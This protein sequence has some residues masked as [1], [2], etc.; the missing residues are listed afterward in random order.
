M[1]LSNS[2]G[3]D[4]DLSILVWPVRPDLGPSCLK[5]LSADNKTDE[6]TLPAIASADSLCKHF[7]TLINVLKKK[8]FEN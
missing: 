6:S 7:G 8:K 2:L 1:S 5:R 4:Q 3:P